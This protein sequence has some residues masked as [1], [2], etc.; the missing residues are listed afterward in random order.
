MNVD[1]SAVGQKF[2]QFFMNYAQA[3]VFESV[4]QIYAQFF[5]FS[6]NKP[7]ND[8][9]NVFEVDTMNLLPTSGSLLLPGLPIMVG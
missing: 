4:V 3:D 6:I 7:L 9:F 5:K 8:R 2:M 1:Y